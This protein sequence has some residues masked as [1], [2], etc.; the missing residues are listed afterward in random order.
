MWQL[1]PA[2][3]EG[4]ELSPIA[5]LG[6]CSAVGPVSQNRIVS[7]MRSAEVVSDSTNAL[8]VEAADRRLLSG[9]PLWPAASEPTTGC[10]RRGEDEAVGVYCS[11]RRTSTASATEST[12]KSGAGPTKDHA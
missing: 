1:L 5:P 9:S 6:T 10:A 7:A 3:V 4:V 12:V 11:R 2:E 8:A